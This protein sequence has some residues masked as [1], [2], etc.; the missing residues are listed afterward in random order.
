MINQGTP[1]ERILICGS[2]SGALGRPAIR[3]SSDGGAGWASG[4]QFPAGVY[5]DIGCLVGD[6]GVQ[7]FWAGILVGG[8][9]LE[10]RVTADGVTWLTTETLVPPDGTTF[11][12]SGNP[13]F[14]VCPDTRLAVIVAPLASGFLA[15]YASMYVGGSIS[16][17]VWVGPQII[18][19]SFSVNAFAIAGG[20]LFA[21]R[22]DMVFASDGVLER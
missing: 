18:G 3:R 10:T 4:S 17:A 7:A 20:R 22:N 8:A 12:V 5:T 13:R 14:L 16:D 15:L 19:P 6:G 1:T 9:G 2:L 11:A 21:T